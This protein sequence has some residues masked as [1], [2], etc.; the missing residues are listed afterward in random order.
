MSNTERQARYRLRHPM[1]AKTNDLFRAA[2]W[3]AKRD[4]IPFTITLE[5]VR[6]KLNAL[7]CE[8]TGVHLRLSMHHGRGPAG[9]YSP[10]LDQIL[11]GKGYTPGNTRLVAWGYNALKGRSQDAEAIQFIYEAAR[12]I[13]CD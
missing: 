3:R 4:K 7:R 5:W 13:Q 11:P 2:K 9:A 1:R 12:G 8:V 10:S 6:E